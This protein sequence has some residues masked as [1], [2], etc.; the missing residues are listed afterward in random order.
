MAV[1]T[2]LTSLETFEAPGA[3]FNNIGSGGGASDNDD[4]YIQGIQ[5]GG[6][7]V[8]NA[9]NKGFMA[10]ITSVDLSAANQHVKIWVYCFHWSAVTRLAA[11]LRSGADIYDDHLYGVGADL[12]ILGGWIPLWVD[13][14]RTPSATG[15]IGGLDEAAVTDIGAYISIGN[16]GGAGDNFIIDEI[17]HGTSGLLW[18]GAG[19]AFSDFV[20]Y[21]TTNVQGVLVESYDAALCF[22]RLTIGDSTATTFTD[23]GFT[24][25]F[26]DQGLVADTWMG[27]TADLQNASTAVTLS[28]GALVS[29]R[30]TDANPKRPDL[31][32]SGT[33]GT[34]DGDT[35]VLNGLRTVELNSACTLTN[36][37]VINSG[38]VDATTAGTTGPDLSGTLIGDSIVAADASALIWNVNENPNTKTQGMTFVKGAN[39]HHAVEFGTSSPTNIT[40]TGITATGFAAGNN[41]NA[42]TFYI[43]RTLGTVFLNIS[44]GT[45][46]FSYKSDGAAVI[47]SID[48]VTILVDVS[49]ETGAALQNARVLMEAGDATGDLPFEESVTITNSGTVATVT[50]T[51]HGLSNGDKVAIRGANEIE[52]NGVF[53]IS[54]AT[55]NT[56]QYS[57][58]ADPGG[59]AT[60]APE[61]TGVII[62][63]LTNASGEISASKNFSVDQPIRGFIRKSTTPPLYKSFQLSGSVD[64]D[65]GLTVSVRM[66]RDDL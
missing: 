55:T 20:S 46:N 59:N 37:V 49:D 34:F 13:V 22:A 40:L 43:K 2:T 66:Q 8:D 27:V 38:V 3:T 42:S 58:S 60:G 1:S 33:A 51:S 6:R 65:N 28:N 18:S 31:I 15:S 25:T 61:S 24:V 56:Y 47:I 35:L 19:G 7:R 53:T 17:T 30:P 9:T 41:L 50:H 26:P 12:P 32:V 4:V 44:G 21:E 23:E 52:Y 14:S 16:V 36:S 48:P 45:G 39:N 29:G 63:G 5:S 11:R 62:E 10:T 64:S 57:M 54:A